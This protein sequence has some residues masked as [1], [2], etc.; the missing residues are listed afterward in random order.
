MGLIAIAIHSD[1]AFVAL[2]HIVRI[3]FVLLVAPLTFRLVS[4][5]Q[6]NKPN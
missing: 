2:H 3:V 4:D 1:V 5:R 6:A